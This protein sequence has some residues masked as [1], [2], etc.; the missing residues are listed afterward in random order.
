M[1]SPLP[2]TGMGGMHPLMAGLLEAGFQVEWSIVLVGR[3]APAHKVKGG[4]EA[5]AA[6]S[7]MRS[8]TPLFSVRCTASSLGPNPPPMPH[9]NPHHPPGPVP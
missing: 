1:Q 4:E 3:H 2:Y 5:C 6:V 8:E 9:R 7:I